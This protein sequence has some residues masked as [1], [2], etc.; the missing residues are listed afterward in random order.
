MFAR[1]RVT[2]A[3]ERTPQFFCLGVLTSN[4]RSV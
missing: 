3:V 1:E 2:E 4:F